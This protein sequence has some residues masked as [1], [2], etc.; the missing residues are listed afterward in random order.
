MPTTTEYRG[1]RAAT[2]ENDDLRVSVLVEGGHVAEIFDKPAGVNPLWTPPW[3]SIEPSSFN[4]ARHTR[5]GPGVDAKLLAGIMGHNLCLDIFGG[6]SHEE[7]AVGL[8]VHGEASVVP[9]DVGGTATEAILQAHL[10]LA[11]L[12]IERRIE[13]R[14]RAVR[15]WEAVEN[16][17]GT[18]RPVGWT[19]H[20]TLG[21]P[22]L[23]KGHTEF[24]TS[25]TRSRTH[26]TTFGTADYLEPAADFDWPE[27]PRLGGGTVDLRR[28]TDAP[29]SSAYTAHLLN[30]AREHAFFV[31]FSAA[32]RLAFGCVWHRA[33]FPWLGIW[34]ENLSRTQAP[35]NGETLTRGMEFG[36]SPFPE[37]RRQMV[38]RARMFDTRTFRWIP[39]GSRVIV[40]YWCVLR[41]A[42][43]V[44]D[45]LEWPV[46]FPD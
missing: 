36:V 3:P 1:R 39:A 19:Q 21:P 29:R 2:I 17:G 35:W 8:P 31:A 41:T 12:Q 26:E 33:D 44:P 23:R 6:P 16:L 45:T 14:G 30:P 18:D 5:Y 43:A 7:A 46:S 38:D 25:A 27:A 24:R 22:F 4:P 42:D 13:L 32:S 20:V 34:E 9:Y 37:S 11:E 15:I 40:E 28:F 10:P